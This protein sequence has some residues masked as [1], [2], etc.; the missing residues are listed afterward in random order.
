[1]I[2]KRLLEKSLM[3]DPDEFTYRTVAKD[4]YVE[5]ILGGI[6]DEDADL[7][8]FTI[9]TGL[10]DFNFKDVSKI[11]SLGIRNWVNLIKQMKA[12]VSYS[13]CPPPVVRQLSR[14]PSFIDKAKVRSVYVVYSCDHCDNEKLILVGCEQF[15]RNPPSV[16]KGID[17]DKCKQSKLVMGDPVDQYFAFAKYIR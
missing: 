9:M 11:T 6:L 10:V 12:E 13:E 7:S 1:M 4:D 5:V 3:D 16:P 15:T 8:E 17:C 14:V 2:D